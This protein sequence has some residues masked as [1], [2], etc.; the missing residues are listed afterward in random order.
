M[1]ANKPGATVYSTVLRRYYLTE[2]ARDAAERRSKTA[3]SK[4][5]PR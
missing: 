2:K 3:K 1:K 5:G 4:N